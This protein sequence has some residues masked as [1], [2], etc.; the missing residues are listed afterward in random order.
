MR[1]PRWQSANTGSDPIKKRK[2][3][4]KGENTGKYLEPNPGMSK[5]PEEAQQ[6]RVKET[7]RPGI[8]DKQTGQ[9]LEPS[10]ILTYDRIKSWHLK[11]ISGKKEQEE[12]PLLDLFSGPLETIFED[13]R[14]QA[15]GHLLKG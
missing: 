15:I 1:R 11:D 2:K 10:N 12:G 7:Y 5:D 4:Q 14:V 6:S 9:L 13:K 8:M 3:Q